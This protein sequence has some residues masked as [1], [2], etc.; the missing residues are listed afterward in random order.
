MLA[1]Y[2]DAPIDDGTISFAQAVLP[3]KSGRNTLARSALA[4]IIVDHADQN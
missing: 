4:G 3:A 1:I 2:D